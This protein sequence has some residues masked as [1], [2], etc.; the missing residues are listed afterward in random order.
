MQSQ[1][2]K[3]SMLAVVAA[4]T[5]LLFSAAASAATG[6][7]V[8]GTLPGYRTKVERETKGTL[9]EEDLRQT[10]LLGS[11][12][13][14]HLNLA[15]HDLEDGNSSQGSE[16]IG[17]ALTLVG[18]VHEMLPVMVETMIVTDSNG[19]EVYRHTQRSQDDLIPIYQEMTAVDVVQP[20]LDVRWDQAAVKGVKLADVDVVHTSVLADLGYIERRLKK[21]KELVQT[22]DKALEQLSL[23]HEHGLRF[24]VEKKD[25]PLLSAQRSLRL[26]EKQ[27]EE[28][29]FTAAQ[30]NLLSARNQLTIYR[31]LIQDDAGKAEV[32]KL[33]NEI[34]KLEHDLDQKSAGV[35]RGFWQ[36]VTGWMSKTPGEATAA[37]DG[38]ESKKSVDSGEANTKR[39]P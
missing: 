29:N 33:E 16:Q 8:S 10:S 39:S 21:A 26:A 5:V 7:S 4:L 28:K 1:P 19:K 22:P 37:K 6:E 11:Q 23:A 25:S 24:S 18:V 31:G 30:A 27:A 15:M 34:Q 2:I 17:K 14:L 20:I 9:S 35:I 3:R 32:Q 12:V 38:D 13:L 36:R